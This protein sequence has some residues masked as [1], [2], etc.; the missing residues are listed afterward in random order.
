L[1][2]APSALTDRGLD[3]LGVLAEDAMLAGPRVSEMARALDATYLYEDGD[4]DEVAEHLM[5][6]PI[7]SDPGQPY[8]GRHE[9]KAVITRFDKT[10]VQL[11]ALES[12]G[13]TCL[14]LSG[15][16]Q[17]SPYILDRV[18]SEESPIL[19]TRHGTVAAMRT[20]EDLYGAT[21]LGGRE[22]L[23]RLRTLSKGLS[24]DKLSALLD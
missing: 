15:G 20:L 3:C 23:E 14:I 8:F 13:L 17:P 9:R 7:S 12:P 21:R 6:G 5:I 24:G 19:L 2:E 1:A 22:K 18:Q 4:S 16:Q 10:D 11:A